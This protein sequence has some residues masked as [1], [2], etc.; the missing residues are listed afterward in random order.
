LNKQNA[1][2]I[3]ENRANSRNNFA[4]IKLEDESM[5]SIR[6]LGKVKAQ[7]KSEEKIPIHFTEYPI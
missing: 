5:L 6:S 4:L 3:I 2:V 7:K 1:S